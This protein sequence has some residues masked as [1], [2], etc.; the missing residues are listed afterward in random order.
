MSI[1]IRYLTNG[2]KTFYTVVN[3]GVTPVEIKL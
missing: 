3:S 1:D 2:K